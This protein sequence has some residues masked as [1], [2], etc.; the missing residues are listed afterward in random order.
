M[1]LACDAELLVVLSQLHNS[2]DLV[3]DSSEDEIAVNRVRIWTWLRYTVTEGRERR[4]RAAF[5]PQ[6]GNPHWRV[7]T[8]TTCVHEQRPL[9]GH[10]MRL[11][12]H[13]M[14]HTVS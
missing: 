8:A 5:V 13:A 3:M 9:Q 12:V 4:C 2:I 11:H 10:S 1:P 14:R 7:K 6:A